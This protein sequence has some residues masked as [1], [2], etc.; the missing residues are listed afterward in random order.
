MVVFQAGVANK[1]SFKSYSHYVLKLREASSL[2]R[3]VGVLLRRVGRLLKPRCENVQEISSLIL[4]DGDV[5]T[6]LTL[7]KY[8]FSIKGLTVCLRHLYKVKSFIC[9]YIKWIVTLLEKAT[10]SVLL[11]MLQ[12]EHSTN[13]VHINTLHLDLLSLT[14]KRTNSIHKKILNLLKMSE[15]TCRSKALP[16]LEAK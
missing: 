16:K 8:V 3:D 6:L 13:L 4:E 10:L 14:R 2:L 12:L 11:S 15:N 1:K 5:L 9:A 7:Q